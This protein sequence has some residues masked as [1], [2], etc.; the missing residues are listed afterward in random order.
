MHAKHI[1]ALQFSYDLVT[2]EHM[3]WVK[4]LDLTGLR[5]FKNADLIKV[6]VYLQFT[7]SFMQYYCGGCSHSDGQTMK[8]TKI[9]QKLNKYILR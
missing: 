1:V 6:L 4:S 9:E 2:K 3:T 7:F 8:T 5:T